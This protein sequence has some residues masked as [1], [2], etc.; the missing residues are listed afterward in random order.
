MIRRILFAILLGATA[1]SWTPSAHADETPAPAAGYTLDVASDDAHAISYEVLAPR[2]ASELGAPVLRSESASSSAR[3]S[4]AI[5]LAS[6]ML[7]VRVVHAGGRVLERTV[8]A[9][10]DDAAVQSEAI[11][12]SANLARD[13]ARELLDALAPARKPPA[14]VPAPPPEPPP[15]PE[16]ERPF[17]AAFV[18][19]LA[20]N[21]GLPNV[22][23]TVDLSLVYGRV[24]QVRAL[25]F[26]SGIAHAS[27]G[28]TGAQL[29]GL[30]TIAG[31]PVRGAQLA[32]FGNLGL[33]DARGAVVAGGAN[34]VVGDV[35]GVELAP[36]NVANGVDGVQLGIVNVARG[37]VRG[38]QLGIVN[39]AEE[40]DGVALG[41]VSVSRNSIHPIVWTSNTSYTNGGVKF[42]TKYMYTVLAFT[43]GNPELDLEGQVG[44][45]VAVGLHLPLPRSL[46]LET[47]G[48]YETV[49]TTPSFTSPGDTRR[50][51][52]NWVHVR[53]IVGYAFAKHLR[54]FVGMGARIPADVSVGRDITRAEVSGGV[55][56]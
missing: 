26:G 4:I 20:T 37:K 43:F 13:E 9:E 41:F 22:T 52:N 5:R 51:Q 38:V 46:D 55:Q 10:G 50:D 24:G 44:A 25:Q 18:Y 39:V 16:E 48:A 19:P 3:A 56:F 2:L 49:S 30:L 28:V 1:A 17:T 12:L 32:G 23:S 53:G 14:P 36:V 29:G 34:V 42:T 27:R 15:P 33:G 21:F 11:L 31:G 7:S 35:E 6:H 54:P 8:K 47:E 40:V 45:S